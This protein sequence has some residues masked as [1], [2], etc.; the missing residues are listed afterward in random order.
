VEEVDPDEAEGADAEDP[1]S[2]ETKEDDIVEEASSGDADPEEIKDEDAVEARSAVIAAAELMFSLEDGNPWLDVCVAMVES[3]PIVV[4][5]YD[6]LEETNVVTVT[7]VVTVTVL[8]ITGQDKEV[9][10]MWFL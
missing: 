1:K 6:W 2:E 10:E 5:L 8:V 9:R 4:E 3:Y 7:E